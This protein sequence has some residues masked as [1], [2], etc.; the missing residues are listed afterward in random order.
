[1]SIHPVAL[2]CTAIL[3]LLLFGLGLVVS[4]SRFLHTTGSGCLPDPTDRLHK[5]VRAHG[6]TA[7]Y[8]PFL[9]VLFLYVGAHAPSRAI[10]SLIV[11]A[12]VCRCLL[13]VGLIVWPTMAR[14]NPVRFIG[15]FGTYLC[16]AAL[17]VSLF[18]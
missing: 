8:A 13:V 4:V 12:T 5:V 18:F 14:P 1:M 11:A 9:A 7:E 6:N 17:C 15:A 10:L 2:F 16:G 3:G